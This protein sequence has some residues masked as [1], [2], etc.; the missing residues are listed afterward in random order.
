M[1]LGRKGMMGV[2]GGENP[3]QIY[4]LLLHPFAPFMWLA[5]RA[6]QAIRRVYLRLQALE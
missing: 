2:G 4:S 6:R 5:S 1:I 3:P